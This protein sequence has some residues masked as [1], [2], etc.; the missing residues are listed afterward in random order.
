MSSR[1]RSERHPHKKRAISTSYPESDTPRGVEVHHMGSCWFWSLTLAR[2]G[3]TCRQTGRQ[4]SPSQDFLRAYCVH[5]LTE[6]S[7]LSWNELN[8]HQ[9]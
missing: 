5:N 8:F 3:Q 6:T 9:P 7:H 1:H 4:S 2:G